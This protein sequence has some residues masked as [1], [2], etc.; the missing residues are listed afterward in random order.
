[1]THFG[2]PNVS[3]RPYTLQSV[4]GLVFRSRAHSCANTVWSAYG[5]SFFTGS[6]FWRSS[7]QGVTFFDPLCRGKIVFFLHCIGEGLSPSGRLV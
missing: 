2:T 4:F 3:I 7:A 5:K 6:K 1:M